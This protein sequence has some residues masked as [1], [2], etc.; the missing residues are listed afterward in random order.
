MID[1]AC[2]KARFFPL[3]NCW[4]PSLTS[5][6]AYTTALYGLQTKAYGKGKSTG[7]HRGRICSVS[8]VHVDLLWEKT[9]IQ[10]LVLGDN[11][12]GEHEGMLLPS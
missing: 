11:S 10:G 1:G 3:V 12:S 4:G 6:K 5:A 9:Q 7:E 2:R 8:K